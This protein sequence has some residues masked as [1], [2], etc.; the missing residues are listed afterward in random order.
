V[1]TLDEASDLAKAAHAGQ[2]DK[3][4][5]PYFLHVFAV[6]DALAGH[7]VDAQIAGVLHDV[8]EDTDITAEDLR[9]AGVPD[10]VVRAVDSVTRRP[11]ETYMELIARAAADPLGRLVKLA[12]NRHNSDEARLA[13]LPADRA[14]RLRERYRKAREV[15]EAVRPDAL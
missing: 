5:E 10:H 4:G 14:A 7:G 11:D 6:R 9:A 3:A 13:L 12:D 2:V 15:L 8:I 1:I